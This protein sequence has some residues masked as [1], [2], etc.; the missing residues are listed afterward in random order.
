MP[1]IEFHQLPTTNKTSLINVYEYI[2]IGKLEG[3]LKA[4]KLRKLLGERYKTKFWWSKKKEKE[5]WLIKY[6]AAS[7]E[8][9]KSNPELQKPWD[10]GSWLIALMNADIVLGKLSID[11]DGTGQLEFEQVSWPSGG[12]DALE[13]LIK[14]HDGEIISND[15]L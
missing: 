6:K 15:A 12:V 14:I 3:S 5:G 4:K 7:V 8:E 9:R 11:D 13:V 2:K 10:F 1:K